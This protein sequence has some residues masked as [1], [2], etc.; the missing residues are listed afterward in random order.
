MIIS[1]F[2]CSLPQLS[3][4]PL[5][6]LIQ[7]CRPY[8]RYYHH[9]SPSQHY[10][11]KNLC[12][13]YMPCCHRPTGRLHRQCRHR[14]HRHLRRLQCHCLKQNHQQPL[15]LY[16]FLR[17]QT[18][19]GS[20]ATNDTPISTAG[21]ATG[22][23]A[24]LYQSPSPSPQTPQQGV[25]VCAYSPPLV[26]PVPTSCCTVIFKHTVNKHVK[27]KKNYCQMGKMSA[28]ASLVFCCLLSIKFSSIDTGLITS[29]DLAKVDVHNLL[30]ILSTVF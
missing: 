10:S 26:N 13:H 24:D 8:L 30:V 2:S 23:E 28:T 6:S 3:P 29:E 17:M 22:T 19:T 7:Y 18:P 4:I 5:S 12:R 20:C 16:F 14:S 1:P 15:H 9:F 25:G 27:D 21:S 11:L